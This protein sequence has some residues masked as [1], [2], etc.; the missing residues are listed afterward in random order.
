MDDDAR[1]FIVDC[2]LHRRVAILE[3]SHETIRSDFD[4]ASRLSCVGRSVR[5]VEELP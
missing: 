5:P 2:D 3:G 4:E 1:L